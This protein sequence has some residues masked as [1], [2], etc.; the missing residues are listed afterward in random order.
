MHEARVSREAVLAGFDA[1]S[2]I[3]GHVPPLIMWRAWEYAAYRRLR[4]PEPVLDVGCGDGRFFR[5]AFPDVQDVVGIDQ[6]EGI[7][8]W[9]RRSQVYRAVYC[10]PAHQI[11]VSDGTFASAFANCAVEHMD[12]LGDVL[13]EIYRVVRP[14]GIFLLSVVTDT[15]VSWAPLRGLLAACSADEAGRAA[16]IRH[17]S[18]H[19]LVNAFPRDEWV[20]RCEDAGFRA[21]SWT[22]IVQGASGW[23]FL[24]LDQLWHMERDG[25]EYGE[26]FAAHLLN[27][28]NHVD[29]LRKIF[30]GLLEM[31]PAGSDYAGLVLL[32]QK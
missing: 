3:Y 31:S 4:L 13:S 8:D 12:H 30:E 32:I 15:F 17:E 16:Q 6:S 1:L 28:A 29:G 2:D 24:L 22:P 5:R 14:G 10:A 18:Y 11:P 27:T 19:H 21:T 25:V 26:G 9:A 7:V 23:S 20:A